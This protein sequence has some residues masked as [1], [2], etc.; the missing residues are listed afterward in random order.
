MIKKLKKMA[1]VVIPYSNKS[2]QHVEVVAGNG[3]TVTR[4]GAGTAGNPFIYKIDVL[5]ATTSGVSTNKSGVASNLASI[6][7]LQNQVNSLSSVNHRQAGEKYCFYLDISV[8]GTNHTLTQTHIETITTSNLTGYKAPTIASSNTAVGVNN[9]YDVSAFMNNAHASYNV[10]AYVENRTD[11][12]NYAKELNQY[13]VECFS[14]ASGSFSFRII[15]D[16]LGL[17]GI[18]LANNQLDGLSLRVYFAI[19]GTK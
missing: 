18:P 3:T 10:K 6:G 13:D 17:R 8:S 12:S 14:K 19:E 16:Q 11:T 2:N 5:S 1:Q 7:V 9:K 15:A 4:T